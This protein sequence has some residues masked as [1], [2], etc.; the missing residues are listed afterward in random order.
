[1]NLKL[2]DYQGFIFDFYGTLVRDA[3][4]VPPMVDILRNLGYQSSE[5]LEKV[6]EPDAFDG[7]QM[8]VLGRGCRAWLQSN[9]ERFCIASGVPQSELRHVV[10]LLMHIRDSYRPEADASANMVLSLLRS[11]GFKV[12]ICSNWESD[13]EVPLR[14]AGIYEYDAVVS[15]AEIGVRKP[16]RLI[17][18]KVCEKISVDPENVIFVGDNWNADIV[19]A[20]HAG[21]TPVWIRNGKNSYF[22]EAILQ[23]NDFTSFSRFLK[24]SFLKK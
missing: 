23:F 2:V 16:N 14:Q 6:Y 11:H 3:N 19:G 4:S 10:S 1:M 8:P 13:I 21:L 5:L 18:E 7:Q 20:L 17:F 9:W 15:S 24:L 22:P 12:G